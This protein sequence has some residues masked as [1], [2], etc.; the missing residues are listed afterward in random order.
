MKTEKQKELVRSFLSTMPN[1]RRPL[2]QEIITYLS[3]LGYNPQKEKANLSFKHDSHNKQMAKMGITK[4]KETDPFFALR[5][6]A[7]QGYSQR[8]TDIVSTAIANHPKKTA[9][10]LS[11]QCDYC[12]GEPHTHVYSVMFDNGDIKS[13]C[14]AYSLEI[15][16]LCMGD[17]EEIKYLIKEEHEYLLQHEVRTV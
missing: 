8:F 3:E 10:C 17:I 11:G 13:H 16:N 7:C 6:S 12:S 2:Y 15:P 5:F 4:G 9:H 1:E 14:G